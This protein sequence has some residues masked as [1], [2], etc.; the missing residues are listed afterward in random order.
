MVSVPGGRAIREYEVLRFARPDTAPVQLTALRIHRRSGLPFEVR[1]PLP[2]DRIRLA[3][4]G[5]KHRKLSDLLIDAKVPR[6]KRRDA[7]VVVDVATGEILWSE[8]V[9]PAEDSDVSEG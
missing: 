1:S 5:G 9:G 3:R 6:D 7:R 2:G 8:F 4:L